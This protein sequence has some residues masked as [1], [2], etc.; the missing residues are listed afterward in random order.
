M[1]IKYI[2]CLSML[3]SLGAYAAEVENKGTTKTTKVLKVTHKDPFDF[4]EEVSEEVQISDATL[5]VKAIFD[6]LRKK[7]SASDVYMYSSDKPCTPLVGGGMVKSVAE[8]TQIKGENAGVVLAATVRWHTLEKYDKKKP[9]VS[10]DSLP[11][12]S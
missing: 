11:A 9:L 8:C 12:K 1:T 3:A 2:L 5:S 6:A 4:R 10:K 7:F